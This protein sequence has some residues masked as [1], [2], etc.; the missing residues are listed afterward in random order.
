M[1]S[2]YST[3]KVKPKVKNKPDNPCNKETN[4]EIQDDGKKI[5]SK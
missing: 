1:C 3:N 2:K 5:L 4:P